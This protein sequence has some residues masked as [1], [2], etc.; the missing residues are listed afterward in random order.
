MKLK[1]GD[2][3]EW[4]SLLGVGQPA[5]STISWNIYD[6]EEIIAVALAYFQKNFP[7]RKLP[8]H[9][10]MQEINQ[11]ASLEGRELERTLLGYH[12]ADTY[13]PHRFE[14]HGNGMMSP[15]EAVVRADDKV[16]RKCLERDF[17]YNGKVTTELGYLSIV[18]GVQE[19]SNF[20]P[21]IAC[22]L[23][24]KYCPEGGTVL[25]TST[26]YGGRLVGFIAS[27]NVER[28]IGI[29]PNTKTYEGNKRLAEDMLV[30]DRVK[31]IHK[32]AEEVVPS[33][34]GLVDMCLTSPP[35]WNREVYS[36]ES[37][38]SSIRYPTFVGWVDNFLFPVMDLQYKCLRVGGV[39]V[40][41]VAD[42][43]SSGKKPK[44]P[45]V[46]ETIKA[47]EE[48]GFK[49]ED[50]WHM[51]MAAAVNSTAWATSAIKSEPCLVFRK[52]K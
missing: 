9:M 33:T 14:A 18:S 30:F 12:V 23:Y 27:Q 48:V 24:R 21:G 26:G 31:L 7:Y 6:K 38:Q 5:A 44:F 11:L 3:L 20:R 42:I 10:S 17:L 51:S 22:L 35:Y 45:L 52:G 32:P 28:Y 50:T 41:N 8:V 2:V 39:S 25:D 13:H 29:D 47:A 36:T 43:K 49:Y 19:A 1:T 46:A 15:V 4:D 16:L 37:T 34:V 40:M